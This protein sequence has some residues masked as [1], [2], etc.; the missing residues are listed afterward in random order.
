MTDARTLAALALV[1][2][3]TLGA[4]ERPWRWVRDRYRSR[5]DHLVDDAWAQAL[6]TLAAEQHRAERERTQAD[7]IAERLRRREVTAECEYLDIASTPW[8]RGEGR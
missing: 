2:F 6:R 1:A 7:A 3:G 5:N 4:W 8:L